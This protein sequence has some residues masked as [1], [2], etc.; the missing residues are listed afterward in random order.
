MVNRG[1]DG[2]SNF[3]FCRVR[4][5]GLVTMFRRRPCYWYVQVIAGTFLLTA[6]LFPA[7]AIAQPVTPFA[8]LVCI[9]ERVI[10]ATKNSGEST[11]QSIQAVAVQGGRITAIGSREDAQS[12][13][14]PNTRV[15]ELAENE[16]LMPGLIESHGHFVGLGQSLMMLDLRTQKTWQ[17]IIDDVVTASRQLPEG[18]WII[19]R[20][21]HQSKWEALPNPNIDGYPIHDDLTMAVPNHPVMLVHASGHAT[22]A[23]SAAMQRARITDDTESPSGG[24]IVR[25]VRGQATGLFREQA[26][27]LIQAAHNRTLRLQSSDEKRDLLQRTVALAAQECLRWGITSFHDA[28]SDVGTI[29][30]LRAL[31]EEKMTGVRLYVMVRDSNDALRENLDRL[32]VVDAANG[33]FTVR[34]I[35]K[36]I[37]GAL[38]PHG[39]WLLSPYEDMPQSTGLATLSMD[40]ARESIE[41]AKTHNYQMCIHAIGDRANREVLNLFESSM[42]PK[43]LRDARWRIE[44]AQHLDPSDVGRFGKLGIIAAMQGIHCTSDAPFV[45]QRLGERRAATGAYRWRELIDGGAVVSNGTDAPVE[46]LN[47]FASIAASISRQLSDGT[48]FFADQAMTI[49]EAIQSYTING[50]VAAFQEDQLG[51]IEVGK[52]ADLIIVDRDLRASSVAEL[53]QTQV[54]MTIIDGNIAYS[55]TPSLVDHPD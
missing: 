13:I 8:D 16:T 11:A 38:G 15:I 27:Q 5:L 23:N 31:A 12:W 46:P 22:F 25:D 21:W 48:T 28:G 41:L 49:E 32:R 17:E 6:C 20:G 4:L 35:K 50:A 26:A 10:T 54:V 36:S 34:A 24:E 30:S 33:F 44:H 1:Y 39:A 40:E 53:R 51:S 19:G 29:D 55:K 37:D 45:L 42:P 3:N 2:R 7:F 47:P 14:G 9:G 52:R 18:S 43:Q